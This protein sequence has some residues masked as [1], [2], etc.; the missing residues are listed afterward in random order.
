M[1]GREDESHLCGSFSLCPNYG[2]EQMLSCRCKLDT[3]KIKY[4]DGGEEW[5]GFGGDDPVFHTLFEGE[6]ELLWDSESNV[7]D[8][9]IDYDGEFLASTLTQIS[10]TID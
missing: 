1:R 10:H 2:A 8:N 3:A 9:Y 5:H 4:F 6:V 7:W